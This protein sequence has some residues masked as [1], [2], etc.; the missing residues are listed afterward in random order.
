MFKDIFRHVQ[1]QLEHT[2][3]PISAPCRAPPA[4]G[5]TRES[6]ALVAGLAGA[7]IRAPFAR[8]VATFGRPGSGRTEPTATPTV[9]ATNN[10]VILRTTTFTRLGGD[11][12]GSLTTSRSIQ[13]LNNQLSGPYSNDQTTAG[14]RSVHESSQTGE[15][16]SARCFSTNKG[17]A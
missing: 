7:D 3:T 11:R 10:T 14:R 5:R 1:E 6:G 17:K 9:A 2:L 4:C 15:R 8:G 16:P 13:M 12:F